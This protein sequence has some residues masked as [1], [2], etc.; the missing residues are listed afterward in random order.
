M[1]SHF[2]RELGVN[3][4]FF[5]ELLLPITLLGAVIYAAAYFAVKH[6]INDSLLG[7]KLRREREAAETPRGPEGA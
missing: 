7:Q 3:I 4:S 2:L 1:V 6:A 5:L